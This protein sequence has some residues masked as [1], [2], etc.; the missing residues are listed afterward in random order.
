VQQNQ[1]DDDG[2]IH[3]GGWFGNL[4]IED[5]PELLDPKRGRDGCLCGSWEKLISSR[6]QKA[7]VEEED[8]GRLC[9]QVKRYT[10]EGAENLLGRPNHAWNEIK[11]PKHWDAGQGVGGVQIDAWQDVGRNPIPSNPKTATMSGNLFP[12]YRDAAR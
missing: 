6:I 11:G 4:F 8:M 5:P 10:W 9:F 1:I 3:A 2:E 7:M 12:R